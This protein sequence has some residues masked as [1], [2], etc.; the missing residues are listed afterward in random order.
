MKLRKILILLDE[1]S[2][3]TFDHLSNLR[4]SILKDIKMSLIEREEEIFID[5]TF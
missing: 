3:Q 2:C 1:V 5:T 4:T